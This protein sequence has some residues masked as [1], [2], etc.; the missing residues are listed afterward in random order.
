MKNLVTLTFIFS[1]IF[2]FGCTKNITKRKPSSFEGEDVNVHFLKSPNQKSHLIK[3][4]NL[5]TSSVGYGFWMNNTLNGSSTAIL[6]NPLPNESLPNQFNRFL[7]L[8]DLYFSH[9]LIELENFGM[10]K[11]HFI[12]FYTPLEDFDFLNTQE[13][14]EFPLKTN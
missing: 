6:R 11:D 7:S 10:N 3:S 13:E 1:F 2:L 9:G 5:L 8:F 12:W 4:F 14:F